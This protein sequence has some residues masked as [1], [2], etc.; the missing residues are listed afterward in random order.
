MD[1]PITLY[2]LFPGLPDKWP[3]EVIPSLEQGSDPAKQ[4]LDTIN[5]ALSIFDLRTNVS[6]ERISISCRY[7]TN[8]LSDTSIEFKSRPI[9]QFPFR[10]LK[11]DF[12]K[13][14]NLF[15]DLGPE[16]SDIIIEGLP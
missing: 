1:H 7:E 5:D 3:Y 9:A 6:S 10:V 13:R 15:I 16:G 8:P 12:H 14:G 4:W 2:D 11:L